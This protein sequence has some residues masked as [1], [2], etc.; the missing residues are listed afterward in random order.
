[1]LI[2]FLA[3]AYMC[4][5]LARFL[6]LCLEIKIKEIEAGGQGSIF[7]FSISEGGGALSKNSARSAKTGA[8]AR[9]SY[10]YNT[11]THWAER[12]KSA[13]T[14]NLAILCL[15]WLQSARINTPREERRAPGF[16]THTHYIHAYI[17][18]C[19]M[20]SGASQFA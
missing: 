5:K 10:V 14:T 16:S 13:E 3:N 2:V 4:A 20:T 11:N 12:Y 17:K 9:V 18:F 1:V 6:L 19:F 7:A 15:P 8:R